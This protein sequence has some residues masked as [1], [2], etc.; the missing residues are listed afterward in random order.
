V[1]PSDKTREKQQLSIGTEL[2][3]LIISD[4]PRV[5][6]R[7]GDTGGPPALAPPLSP[8][9][10]PRC[11][12]RRLPKAGAISKD[13]GGRA[14][15]PHFSFVCS[16]GAQIGRFK[17]QSRGCRGGHRPPRRRLPCPRRR[18]GAVLGGSTSGPAGAAR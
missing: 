14:F 17:F 9:F 7:S 3:T 5:V 16:P 1:N 13:G 10:P 12:R 18:R 2:S 6:L 4:G 11:R 15:L 8:L